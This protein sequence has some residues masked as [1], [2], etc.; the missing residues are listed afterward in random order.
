MCVPVVSVHVLGAAFQLTSCSCG[1]VVIV[2]CHAFVSVPVPAPLPG[3]ESMSMYAEFSPP[4]AATTVPVSLYVPAFVSVNCCGVSS[5][6]L[7]VVPSTTVSGG[8]G[9]VQFAL[10][11]PLIPLQFQR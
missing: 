1:V 6:M 2:M 7:S 10:V 8:F 5:V 4:S 3:L 9:S 11:P